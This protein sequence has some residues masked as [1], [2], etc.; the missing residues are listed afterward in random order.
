MT[1]TEFTQLVDT[2]LSQIEQA[3]AALGE[4]GIRQLRVRHHGPLARIEVEPGDFEAVLSRRDW[5]VGQLKALGY[6]YVTLDLAGFRSGSM[7]EVIT[8]NGHTKTKTTAG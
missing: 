1:P 4:L 3:E 7:N 6:T 8:P 2:T 5:V